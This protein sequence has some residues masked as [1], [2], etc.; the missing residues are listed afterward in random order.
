[1]SSVS[2]WSPNL[3]WSI[4]IGGMLTWTYLLVA[5]VD[6][7]PPWFRFH[8]TARSRLLSWSKLGHASAYATLTFFVFLLPV[9]RRTRLALWALISLHTMATE[10]IQTYVPTRSGCWSD[11]G[12]D[13]FGIAVGLL[14]GWLLTRQWKPAAVQA[15]QDAG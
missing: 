3:R 1:M 12:I 6:W 2:P 13:H 11:V 10:W 7:L 5:P 14:S 15:E 4:W 8:G 9:S